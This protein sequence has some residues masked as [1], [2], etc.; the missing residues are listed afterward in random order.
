MSSCD[1]SHRVAKSSNVVTRTMEAEERPSKIRKMSHGV[2]EADVLVE[3]SSRKPDHD[4]SEKVASSKGGQSDDQSDADDADSTDGG[5][6]LK[7]AK[8]PLPEGMSK[9]AWKKIQKK[10]EW[11]AGRDARKVKRKEKIHAKKVRDREAKADAKEAVSKPPA[12]G[13]IKSNR[14]KHVKLPVTFLIDCGFDD[15]MMEKE[16]ISLGSQLTRSYS[17]NSRALFQAH[18]VVSSWGG[19]LK[20]RFDTVLAKHHEN[21]RGV[22]FTDKDFVEGAKMAEESMKG[23]YGGRMEGIFTRYRA[24]D[25]PN[26]DIVEEVTHTSGHTQRDDQNCEPEGKVSESFGVLSCDANASIKADESKTGGSPQ[27]EQLK[28]NAHDNTAR[29]PSPAPQ[30]QVTASHEIQ[31]A[32]EQ[33]MDSSLDLDVSAPANGQRS[34]LESSHNPLRTA[35]PE[36]EPGEVIYLTSDSPHTLDELKPYS[37]YIIGGL[38]DK[39]RHKGICYR[40]ACEK[41]LKTAKL[42]IGEFMEMQSRFVLATNHVVAIMVRWLECGDWGK[43]FLDVIPKRKGGKLKDSDVAEDSTEHDAE[44]QEPSEVEE[45]TS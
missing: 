24:S 23:K 25:A 37:T 40:I 1:H 14:V 19:Q 15:L 6:S 28:Q 22:V 2:T 41:G 38:V 20:E 45:R 8:V 26:R 11:E 39:N 3:Q 9:N 30:T 17:D 34:I 7:I 18:M 36:S 42:P 29:T 44:V 35:L 4:L 16:R 10:T 27:S 32:T 43:A 5:V 33:E 13:T 31:E 12:N 21:W